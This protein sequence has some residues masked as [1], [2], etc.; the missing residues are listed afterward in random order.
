MFGKKIRKEE[1]VLRKKPLFRYVL[2]IT[3]TNESLNSNKNRS[4]ELR[5]CCF[6]SDSKTM[7][8]QGCFYDLIIEFGQARQIR[9]EAKRSE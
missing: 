4:H 7:C 2:A 5:I 6:D 1:K 8:K 3:K 9:I